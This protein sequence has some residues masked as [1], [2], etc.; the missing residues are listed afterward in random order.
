MNRLRAMAIVVVA[1]CVAAPRTAH[2]QPESTGA[3]V[4]IGVP[5]L[6]WEDITDS[7]T[8]ALWR[9]AG[10]SAIGSLSVRA[11]DSVTVRADGWV[12][13]GAGNR[14]TGSSANADLPSF[15]DDVGALRARNDSLGLD[16]HVGALGDSLRVAGV[17]R[18]AFGPGAAVALADSDGGGDEQPGWFKGSQDIKDIEL[19]D[20][21]ANHDVA[22]IEAPQLLFGTGR[23]DLAGLDSLVASVEATLTAQD[24]LIVAGVSDRS[25]E[26]PHL[27][28]AMATGPSYAAGLLRSASTRRVGFVQLID[29]A[30]TI[31]ALKGVHPNEA[32]VGR[33]WT[34][35]ASTA[36][37]P[38][39]ISRLV[40][41]DRAASGY[42]RYV[43]PFFVLLFLAQL[44]IYA[45]AY[46]AL[47]SS[48]GTSRRSRVFAVTR[49]VALVFA[50][51]PVSTFLAHLMPWWR[52][53]IGY[54]LAVVAA[55]SLA[56]YAVAAAGPWH[57]RPLGPEGFI[58]GLTFA[59]IGVDLMT[60]ARLQL[61][62]PSGY[63]PV[64]AG[65]FAGIGN[66]GF[67]VFAT[68]A[69][70]FAAYLSARSS[71]RRA[72]MI[73]VGVG[74]VAVVVDGNPL[75]GSDFGG[76]LALVPAFAVL[77][78]LLSGRRISFRLAA[79][80]GLAAVAVV[81][82]FALA[83]YA[84]P[85]ASQTHLGRF[86]GQLLHGGAGDVIMRKARANLRLLTHSAVTF[87]VPVAVAAASLVLLR[88]PPA[89]RRALEAVPALR[90][91]LISVLVMGVAGFVFND[92]GVAI[93]ALAFSVAVPLALA[94][95]MQ[96]A[97]ATDPGARADADTT[98]AAQE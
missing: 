66:V 60:G 59:V 64:V 17:K 87:V 88:P 20:A 45:A 54:L 74:V 49:G 8:P 30:P 27:R 7:V 79:A 6:R 23:A 72:A 85:A 46:F 41:A 21:V 69:L 36:S 77:A 48:P 31:L 39:R 13:L 63:S 92:S 1:L 52:Y 53:P 10:R 97:A 3:V 93:P 91:G 16:T 71:R 70:L 98:M 47:R 34:R 55:I 11:T 22:V 61:S 90:A 94:T 28:V 4:V 44:L 15:P 82:V 89:L 51:V 35:V 56:V 37:S 75:W 84:R 29:L 14:A 43:L 73:V 81:A 2:A 65:R 67:A 42:R 38:E 57:R 86:A 62:S 32:M 50:A 26:A 80:I 25:G 40:D 19:I 5:A 76:V 18:F 83:D 58:A 12:T 24:T 95:A 9:L 96:Y 68:G 33:P 78:L